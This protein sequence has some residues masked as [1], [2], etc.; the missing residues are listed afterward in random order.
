VVSDFEDDIFELFNKLH[1][2]SS[3][4]WSFLACW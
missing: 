3:I 4:A 2:F 1:S